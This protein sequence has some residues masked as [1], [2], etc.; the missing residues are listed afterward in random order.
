MSHKYNIK[1][2]IKVSV[3][4]IKREDIPINFYLPKYSSKKDWKQFFHFKFNNNFDYYIGSN[5]SYID[6]TD[7]MTVLSVELDVINESNNPYQF[8]KNLE[9]NY[10]SKI[11]LKNAIKVFNWYKNKTHKVENII[12][13]FIINN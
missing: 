8:K 6:G 2:N 11:N 5:K 3:N 9:I 10:D 13:Q 4:I 1:S 7:L 12:N